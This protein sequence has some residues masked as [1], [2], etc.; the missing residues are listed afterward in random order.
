LK[1]TWFKNLS[2]QSAASYIENSHWGRDIDGNFIE[3]NVINWDPESGILK[4][5]DGR[6]YISVQFQ[7]NGTIRYLEQLSLIC[8][9]VIPYP[10][11]Y[12]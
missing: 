7:P 5:F 6:N 2:A 12:R 4:F 3:L 9:N 8:K 11:Q 1:N 10:G